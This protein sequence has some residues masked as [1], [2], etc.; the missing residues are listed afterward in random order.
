MTQQR[1]N[2]QE[3]VSGSELTPEKAKIHLPKKAGQANITKLLELCD[4]ATAE[5]IKD[6][7]MNEGRY[8]AIAAEIPKK[9]RSTFNNKLSVEEIKQLLKAGVIRRLNKGE[10]MVFECK[11]FTI[12]EKKKRRK[13]LI[14][15]PRDLNKLFKYMKINLPNI[16]RCARW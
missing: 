15:E 1:H 13:R 8:R 5:E 3:P 12:L 16:H 9:K 6:I 10:N 14:I 2:N 7:I 4:K 11:L